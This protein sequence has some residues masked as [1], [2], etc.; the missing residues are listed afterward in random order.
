MGLTVPQDP[1]V[2]QET[3]ESDRV[4][5]AVACYL[6]DKFGESVEDVLPDLAMRVQEEPMV[7]P[8]TVDPSKYKDMF[9]NPKTFD[10][11]WNHPDPFQRMKWR[12][13]ILK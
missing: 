8:S 3:K 11:A 6:V 5:K 4:A 12:E 9:E 1:S 7:D 2:E 13:A 10:E